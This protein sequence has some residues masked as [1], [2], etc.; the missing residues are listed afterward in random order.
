MSVEVDVAVSAIRIAA[1]GGRVNAFERA[2][3][4][5]KKY[6]PTTKI[7]ARVLRKLQEELRESRKLLENRRQSHE[8]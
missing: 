8:D 1:S 6:A 5:V 3:A 2:I 7:R 4:I